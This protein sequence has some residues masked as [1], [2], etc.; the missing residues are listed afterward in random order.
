M[1]W[2]VGAILFCFALTAHAA[3][4]I[5][6][7][8]DAPDGKYPYQVSLRAPSS[9]LCGGS[10]LNKRW[11]L[12]AAHCALNRKH[13]SLTVVVGTNLLNG[14]KGQSYKSEY[15]A[16]HK[17]FGMLGLSHDKVQPISLPLEDFTK[18]DYPVV[19]TGW[20]TT[21][22]GGNVP[23]KLQEIALKVISQT[24][25]KSELN[26]PISESHTLTKSGEGACHGDSGG[27][28]VADGIQ[29]GIVSFGRP[30]AVGKPDVFTRVF[31][32]LGWIEEQM[33]K[34]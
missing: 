8:S 26:F 27:P 28:L 17:D 31:T 18:V 2:L 1:K 10:I 3:P 30:C 6:G 4:R 22:L 24:K 29:I 16:W 20:G 9:H 23:N 12:T 7:G 21:R 25:C 14:G 5:V 11:I 32:F 15:I 19:L 33:A 34:F 13:D